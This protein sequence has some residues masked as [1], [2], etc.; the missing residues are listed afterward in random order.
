[1]LSRVAELIYWMAR[2]LERAENNARIV[3]VNAQLVLD[4]QSRQ[5][6]DD[7]RSWAPLVY[8]SGGHEAY[9]KLY[10]D[11]ASERTVVEF[12]LFDR[13]NS[14]SILSC[15]SQARENA[16]CIR[17]QLSSEVWEALNTFYLALKDDDFS[18]YAQVGSAEYLNRIKSR[19]QL[20]YGVAESMLPRTVAWWFFELGRHLERADNVSRILDVKYFMLLPD[21]TDVGSALDMVQ[22]A[23]V[24]RSCSGFEA[25]RKSRRG[26]LSLERVV[27][28]LM[29][30][31]FFP[32][33]I[34]YSVA[35]AEQA[36]T[37]LTAPPHLAGN[38][39]AS[40]A[41]NLRTELEQADTHAI[42]GGGL[43]EF[44]D[45]IQLRIGVIHQAVQTTF[46]EYPTAPAVPD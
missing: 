5:A 14:S 44:L 36:L 26:Q 46:I 10:G 27:D 17:D 9:Q 2:Q 37:R 25:F 32:R 45:D 40:L 8:V 23:S 24:L 30:D 4:M 34:L 15:V 38:P 3:D 19:L 35:E 13:R 21:Y 41:G 29:R 12:M 31:E 28:Y 39:A 42:I 33:S 11:T 22:W 43:H 6:A 18:R 20:F 7:P 1:M 16:R